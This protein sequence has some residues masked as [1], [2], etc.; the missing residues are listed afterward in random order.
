MLPCL[1]DQSVSDQ[2]LS[3]NL[4]LKCKILPYLAGQT[5]SEQVLRQVT[6]TC[7]PIHQSQKEM[8]EQRSSPLDIVLQAQDI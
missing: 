2:V 6:H 1:A 4:T 5:V 3:Q 7:I 8:V